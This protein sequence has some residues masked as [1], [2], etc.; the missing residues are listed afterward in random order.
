MT[1]GFLVRVC[2]LLLCITLTAPAYAWNYFGHMTVACVAYKKLKPATRNRV[3]AL[4]KLNP[5]YHKWEEMVPANTSPADKDMILFMIAS[6]WADQIKGAPNYKDDSSNPNLPDGPTS[7]QNVGYADFFRHRYWHFVDVPFSD[8]GT[9]LPAI[10]SPNIQE[11]IALFRKVLASKNPDELKSYDLMWLS[12]LVGDVHQPLH[13]VARIEGNHPDG[14][15]GGNTE[16]L[17]CPG[18][19]NTLHSFWDDAL[20][21]SENPA[22]AIKAAESLP[23]ADRKLAKKKNEKDW[24]KE[25]LQDAQKY[26]YAKPSIQT[27]DGPFALTAQYKSDA[28]ALA[29][30]RVALAG[31]RLANLLNRELK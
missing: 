3:N 6:T 2:T 18:C 5:D 29:E 4:L 26:V 9:P 7:S 31:A 24:V 19:P 27:G 21:N 13:C 28:K 10:P 12:H 17:H 20:G 22:D 30:Q 25:G 15:K 1:K 14:D 8:D 23:A 16:R 11:R